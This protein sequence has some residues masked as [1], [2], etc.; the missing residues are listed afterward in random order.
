MDGHTPASTDLPDLPANIAGAR[1]GAGRRGSEERRSVGVGERERRREL[2]LEWHKEDRGR[3]WGWRG[4]APAGRKGQRRRVKMGVVVYNV[5][6][7][8]VAV[9]QWIRKERRLVI[10]KENEKETVK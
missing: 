10:K 6:E 2:D 5:R 8:V 9:G 1:S 7:G 4:G 3:R